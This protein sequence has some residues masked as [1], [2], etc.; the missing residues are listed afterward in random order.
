MC[1]STVSAVDGGGSDNVYAAACDAA[2]AGGGNTEGT[3][4]KCGRKCRDD[5]GGD[6]GVY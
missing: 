3:G 4:G 2:G 1:N 6:C 5:G